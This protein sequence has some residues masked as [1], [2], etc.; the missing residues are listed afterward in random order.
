MDWSGK[1][2]TQLGNWEKST[3]MSIKKLLPQRLKDS[4]KVILGR[5]KVIPYGSEIETQKFECP[6]CGSKNISFEPLPPNYFRELYE[7]QHIH[8]V[9]LAETI[10]LEFYYCSKCLATDRDRLYAIYFEKVIRN[11]QKRLKILDIAPTKALNQFLRRQNNFVVRTAD[12]YMGDVDDRVDITNMAIY[13]DNLF[14]VF[15]CS[16]VLE[17][18]EDD[19][20]AMREL[21]RI[22]K[23]GGWGIAMVPINLGLN[24]IY[25][26]VTIKSEKDRWKHFGQEDHVR[27]YSKHGFVKRLEESGFVVNQYDINF[28]GKEVFDRFGIHHRSV[29]YVVSKD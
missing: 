19:I 26:N 27:M 8:A 24:E 13:E 22:T 7:N 23:P 14:D 5:S 11:S 12:L 6:L 18:V 1:T 9:F 29:L 2:R 15:I 28:F 10:N 16:H 4:I 20:S 21:F 3:E 17:H 25:E